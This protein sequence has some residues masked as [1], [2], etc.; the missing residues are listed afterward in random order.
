MHRLPHMRGQRVRLLEDGIVG[1]EELLEDVTGH[2]C[3]LPLSVCVMGPC[4][5]PPAPRYQIPSAAFP[6]LTPSSIASSDFVQRIAI[7]LLAQPVSFNCML[8]AVVL[9][10]HSNT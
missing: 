7:K 2:A 8:G 3:D 9:S 5:V 10:A 6:A 4:S 1:I